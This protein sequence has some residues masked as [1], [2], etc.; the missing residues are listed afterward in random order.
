MSSAEPSTDKKDAPSATATAAAVDS[1]AATS[2][3]ETAK[4]AQADGPTGSDKDAAS[5]EK[6]TDAAKA[7]SDAEKADVDMKD[8]ADDGA[9]PDANSK[10]AVEDTKAKAARRKST[11]AAEKGGK[12]L[13]KKQ[14]KARIT[15]LNAAPGDLYLVKLKGFPLARRSVRLL[16]VLQWLGSQHFSSGAIPEQ[17]SEAINDKMRKDLQA[18]YELAAEGHDLDYYKDLLQQF[19]E[20]LVAKEEAKKTKKS[21]AI[22]ADS[23]DL[24]VEEDATP[25]KK[26]KKR[27]AEDET[28]TPQRS[29]SVKK[30]K[31]KLLSSAAKSSNG[32]AT[33]KAAKEQAT[34]KSSKAKAKASKATPEEPKKPEL[35]PEERQERRVAEVKEEDMA[36]MSEFFTRLEKFTDMD[37]S[38]LKATRIHKVPKAI[39]RMESIP[40]EDEFNFKT[41]SQKLLD[42]WNKLLAA[43]PSPAD[44]GSNGVNGAEG[45]KESKAEPTEAEEAGDKAAEG[46]KTESEAADK[47]EATDK[48]SEEASG[49]KAKAPV[50]VEASA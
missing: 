23:M 14:S 44:A 36:S 21:K 39:L 29:D 38:I 48:K 34:T 11:G 8:A 13:N 1:G 9:A 17:A 32:S 24:D 18:A 37:A 47:D 40:K 46:D 33:P 12:K 20:E 22:A 4:E 41:R 35:T 10:T 30:P 7:D 27:K 43:D 28:A 16:I 5:P 6:S 3:G 45:K 42:Q 15:N 19:Q 2:K 49:D 31:I 50:A 25:A 26:S